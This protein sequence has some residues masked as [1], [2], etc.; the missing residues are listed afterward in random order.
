MEEYVSYCVGLKINVLTSRNLLVDGN[1]MEF[2][3]HNTGEWDRAFHIVGC[4]SPVGL[5]GGSESRH[6]STFGDKPT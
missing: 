3:F 2:S 6:R 5:A 1:G 4:I